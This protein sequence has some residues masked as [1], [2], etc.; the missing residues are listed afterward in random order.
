MKIT[1]LWFRQ[2]LRISDHE[3]LIAAAAK[4]PVMPIYIAD[5]SLGAASAWWVH[6]SLTSLNESLANK[7]NFYQGAPLEILKNIV[8][9]YDVEAIYWHRCYEPA[10]I[11]EDSAIKEYFKNTALECKS[12]NGSLL[13]EPWQIKKPDQSYYKVFTYF[14]RHGCLKHQEPKHPLAPPANLAL[15]KDEHNQTTLADLLLLKGSWHE[16]FTGLWQ[17]GEKAAL[18]TLHNFVDHHLRGYKEQRNMPAKPSCS[19]LSPHLHFGEVSPNQVWYCAKYS[20]AAEEFAGD[21]DHFL[22]EIGWREF[23]YYLLYHFPELEHENFQSKFNNY[24]WERNAQLL[25]LWQQGKT[26]YPIVDAGMRELWQTGYMH[27]RVRMI[28][29]SFLIKNLNIHW[30]DGRDW[31]FDCLLDADLANNSASWQWVAGCGADAAP[32]YRIFNPVIQGEK[33][34]PEGLYTKKFLPELKRLPNKYLFKPWLAPAEELLKANV[35]LGKNYPLPIVDLNDSR[36]RAMELFR[37]ISA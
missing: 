34:D 14:Y 12:F 20:A 25:T 28:V 19:R 10:R 7:L 2:D 31:F 11:K 13:W 9:N 8:N 37:S 30:H 27:N 4:G 5:N 17:I 3:A 6:H 1:I 23:S 21:V 24:P 16:K 15:V 29:A 32:Y 18:S 33:F 35:L 36:N 22:S 26:G